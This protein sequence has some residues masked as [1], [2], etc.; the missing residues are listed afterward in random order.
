VDPNPQPYPDRFPHHHGA[1]VTIT[2]KDG[3]QFSTTSIFRAGPGPAGSNGADVDAK[4][5]TLVPA[6]KL[7]PDKIEASL[8]VVHEFE[9]VKTMSELT[10]PA[11]L[12][13]GGHRAWLPAACARAC[14]CL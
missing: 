11:E 14:H 1:T 10:R 6:R 7:A 9:S 12:T 13:D 8:K 4:Y 5:R 2:L 3:R